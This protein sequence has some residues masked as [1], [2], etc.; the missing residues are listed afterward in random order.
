MPQNAFRSG[1]LAG[2]SSIRGNE[3]APTIPTCSVETGTNPYRAGVARGVREAA[4][5]K[6]AATGSL[7]IDAWFDNALLYRG[8]R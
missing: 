6:T 4:N 1:F 5:P 3:P 8:D 7:A 2:W